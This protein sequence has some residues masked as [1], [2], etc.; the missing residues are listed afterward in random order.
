MA[1]L[2]ERDHFLEELDAALRDAKAGRGTVAL[3]YGEAGI[4]KTSVVERFVEL[5]RQSARVMWG[6]CD[7]LFT[8]DPLGPLH[9]MAMHL[10]EEWRR[11]LQAGANRPALFS[12]LAQALRKAGEP[13]ILVI[14]D[15]HWADAAT[16][17]LLKYV[18]RRVQDLRA[19]V[20][21]TY[22]D[23]E[24]DH[25]H[26]LWSVL[27][28]L[29]ARTVRRLHL[30]PLSEAAVAT[31]AGRASAQAK[32]IHELSGGNPFFVVELLAHPEGSLPATIRQA[33]LARSAH[34]SAPARAVLDFCA[35]VPGRTERWLLETALHPSHASLDEAARTGL[36]VVENEAVH[37]RHELA[38]RALEDAL[39]AGQAE[40]THGV[41][42]AALLARETDSVQLSR[43]VHHAARARDAATVIR[44]A[45]AAARHAASLGAHREAAAHYATAIAFTEPDDVDGRATLLEKRAHECHL[46][47]QIDPAIA[48]RREAL[49]L[50]R[51]Q[52]N[53]A[54][55]GENLQWLSRLHWYLGARAEATALSDDS[56][57]I[58]TGLPPGPELALAYSNRSTLLM[59]EQENA[60][61]IAWG[62]RALELAEAL[63]LTEVKTYTLNTVGC[64]ELHDG[65]EK[66]WAT[67][68][69]SL[70][71]AQAH[72]M[73][74]NVA[75]AYT[76]LAWHAVAVRD[77]RR[78]AQYLEPG[79]AYA[80]ERELDSW[81]FYMLG[82][83]ARAYLDQGRWSDAA[84][85]AESVLRSTHAPVMRLFPLVVLGLVRVRRGD[86]GGEEL[87]DQAAELA[88]P[89]GEITR[90]GPVALATAEA[91]W[92]RGR[93][94]DVRQ[95]TRDA[96]EL[97]LHRR[98]VYLTG[99][100]AYWLWR[101][102][103]SP[104]G[105]APAATPFDLQIKGEWQAAAA[106]WERISC[107]Y[108]EALALADGDAFARLK[109]LKILDQ[110]GAAPAAAII[111]RGLRAEGVRGVPRGVRP[112]TRR[113]EAGLTAR[114]MTILELLSEGLSNRDIGGRLGISAKTV[115]HHVS[116]VLGK[117][118]VGSR[119]EA[120]A[121]ARTRGLFTRTGEAPAPK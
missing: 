119:G 78:G 77:Y 84:N 23:D 89:T 101:A 12:G 28:N 26:P 49:A 108:E 76:N 39:P 120:A 104:L 46:I 45:Q 1:V 44:Y 19:L 80:I 54:L 38:R 48:A 11:Q 15:V 92:L 86:P 103:D 67:L 21:L 96:Y 65:M 73:E 30:P 43:I 112:A 62:N 34:A 18:G 72:D 116:A 69:R 4:G 68:E 105:D 64:A 74:G 37:F 94:P 91:A 42:L 97:A 13:F 10:P 25:A 59:L 61:A 100:L 95:A 110:L 41:V 9:D 7:P 20:I 35:L 111:R 99:E 107:P 60:E 93:L 121:E 88:R 3:V 75:R 5:R 8:P 51:S 90:I 16:L 40:A 6:R 81:T 83:R 14:E 50:R 102:G 87:I 24:V 27:G 52:H 55:E 63:S 71:L 53:R 109:A 47:G 115:D 117:L 2:L 66:G 118:G 22:R 33:T 17:D 70:D 79:L 29:P 56:I 98:D 32:A 113:N 31:L 85:D 36:L 114:E 57:R 82:V 58:L 106:E